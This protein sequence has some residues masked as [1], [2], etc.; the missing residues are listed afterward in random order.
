M[1]NKD[2]IPAKKLD[3]KIDELWERC[4][5]LTWDIAFKDDAVEE[6]VKADRQ[7]HAN[8]EIKAVLNR[9]KEQETEV[10]YG[11]GKMTPVVEVSAIEA[12]LKALNSEKLPPFYKDPAI[13]RLLTLIATAVVVLL[14]IVDIT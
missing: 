10:E 9:L 12:E 6:F 3:K 2:S 4:D 11:D 7:T 13:I 8:E 1:A 5:Q 14:F